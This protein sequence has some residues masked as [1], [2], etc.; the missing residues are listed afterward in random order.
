MHALLRAPVTLLAPLLALSSPAHAQETPAGVLSGLWWNPSESG[1]GINLT[2]RRDVIFAV[3]F[4]YDAA[5]APRWLTASDCRMSPPPPCPECIQNA[6]CSG[7][8]HESSGPR[9]FNA[10]FDPGAVVTRPVGTLSIT[11]QGVSSAVMTYTLEGQGRTVAIQR[12]SS[13]DD[14]IPPQSWGTDLWW[15]P[16]ESGWGL[17][18]MDQRQSRFLVLFAYDGAGKPVWYVT[19]R[20]EK[21]A[22]GEACRGPLYRPAGPAFG[23]IFDPSRVRLTEVGSM[24]FSFLRTGAQLNWQLDGASGDKR[25]IPQQF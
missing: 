18:V 9:F 1:W 21:Y 15:N 17:A 24:S 5:G 16:A 11:F 6:T 12:Q 22:S 23:P 25:V 2:Q 7:T 20:C 3:W 14:P 4:T 8:L 13:P 10:T 19:S